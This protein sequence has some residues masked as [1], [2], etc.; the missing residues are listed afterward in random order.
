MPQIN[1][2]RTEIIRKILQTASNKGIGLNKTKIMYSAFLTHGQVN[3]YLGH[4]IDNNLLEQ[5]MGNQKFRITEK[6]L[7]YLNLCEQI[8]DLIEKKNSNS[9]GNGKS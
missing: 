6:G 8:G 7:G 9:N 4:L 1:R 3:E 5:D 2:S